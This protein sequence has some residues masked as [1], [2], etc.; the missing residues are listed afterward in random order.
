MLWLFEKIGKLSLITTFTLTVQLKL[1]VQ[2]VSQCMATLLPNFINFNCNQSGKPCKYC[3]MTEILLKQK[4][5]NL[6]WHFWETGW[7]LSR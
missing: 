1:T 7:W 2:L 6:P 4:C 3:Q 5:D